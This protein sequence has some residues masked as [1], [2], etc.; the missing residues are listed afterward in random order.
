M[1]QL[2]Q[3][4][5]MNEGWCWKMHDNGVWVFGCPKQHCEAE[6]KLLKDCY[7]V[8][9]W[10]DFACCSYLEASWKCRIL[11]NS[12]AAR[13]SVALAMPY[14]YIELLWSLILRSFHPTLLFQKEEK[15]I[16]HLLRAILFGKTCL[17]QQSGL[18]R[19]KWNIDWNMSQK[20]CT[21]VNM[22][23]WRKQLCKVLVS[24]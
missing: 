21:L 9:N 4:L 17:N 19:C 14:T 18:L 7:P 8:V 23:L 11:L 22:D 3:K 20:S 15:F 5:L 1:T 6:E 12:L 16:T 13:I 10:P 2:K 24:C